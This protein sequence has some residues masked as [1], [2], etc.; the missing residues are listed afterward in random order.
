M[1]KKLG[2]AVIGAVV[3]AGLAVGG[4]GK[5]A[6]DC[7]LNGLCEYGGGAGGSG[8]ALSSATSSTGTGG[9][10]PS[11]EG[12]PTT[13]ATLVREEC[14]VFLSASAAAGGKGTKTNPYQT[15]AEASAAAKVKRI[16]ACAESYAE[17]MP[18]VFSR[19]P[20]FASE[21]H[22]AHVG[23]RP[24]LPPNERIHRVKLR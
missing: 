3:V 7:Y 18:V 10:P 5:R 14:G 9:T 21:T 8:G 15:F 13:D 22:K 20:D 19:E 1:H 2:A 23:R 11:C 6:D 4:C 24:R 12:D 17:T 16:Y